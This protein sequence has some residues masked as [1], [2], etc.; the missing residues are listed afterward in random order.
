MRKTKYISH[1]IQGSLL[2]A[3][4]VFEVVLISLAIFYLYFSFDE[5]IDQQ[6]YSIHRKQQHETLILIFMELIKVIFILSIINILALFLVHVFWDQ[7]IKKVLKQFR[8]ELKNIQS[9]NFNESHK[10][11]KN[12]H[13]VLDLVEKWKLLEQQRCLKLTKLCQQLDE[14][15]ESETSKQKISLT[16]KE[17]DQLLP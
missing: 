7:Y 6:I 3:L 14:Q 17:I 5:I 2:I 13:E 10:H 12:L 8:H 1:Q 16:L 4:I 9:L 11:R 15:L